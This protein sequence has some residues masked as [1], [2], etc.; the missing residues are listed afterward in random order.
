[1]KILLMLFTV[2]LFAGCAKDEYGRSL[3][4]G[5]TLQRWEESMTE[6]EARLQNKNYAN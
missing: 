1:M 5:Q 6:T 3:G 4:I 2:A